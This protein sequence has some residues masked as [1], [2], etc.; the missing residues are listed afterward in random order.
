MVL[1][2]IK[3]LVA[4]NSQFELQIVAENVVKNLSTKKMKQVK[5]MYA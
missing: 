4:K 2:I 1:V 3:Q 5:F